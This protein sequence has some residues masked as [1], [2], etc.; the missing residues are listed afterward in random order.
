MIGPAERHA[1]PLIG[2]ELIVLGLF[3]RGE[4]PAI[5]FHAIEQRTHLCDDL[6]ATL[7]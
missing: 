2:E 5:R 6:A 4:I 3:L 7:A 1:G